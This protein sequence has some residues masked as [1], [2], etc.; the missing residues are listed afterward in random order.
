MIDAVKNAGIDLVTTS[1]NHSFDTGLNG[2][3]RTAQQLKKHD[4]DFIGTYEEK[5]DS[6]IKM[7]EI[8]EIKVGFIS[9]YG[10]D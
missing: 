6:R 1:N 10:N 2:L 8:N 5:P 7:K 4:L 9:L 3:K